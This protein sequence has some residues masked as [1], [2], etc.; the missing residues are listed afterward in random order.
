MEKA[1]GL[2]P[3]PMMDRDHKNNYSNDQVRF[4]TVSET[5]FYADTSCV[6]QSKRVGPG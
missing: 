2:V 3:I 1:K 6:F 4:S 5:S